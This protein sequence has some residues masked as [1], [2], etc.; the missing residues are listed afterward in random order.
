MSDN[1]IFINRR[2]LRETLAPALAADGWTY[3]H[4]PDWHGCAYFEIIA[5][6]DSWRCPVHDVEGVTP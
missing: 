6:G 5:A 2:F 3:L 1:V 4:C